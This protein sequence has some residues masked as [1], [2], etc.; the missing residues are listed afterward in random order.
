MDIHKLFSRSDF[1]NAKIVANN[2]GLYTGKQIGS[3][4]YVDPIL[5]LTDT[6]FATI[7]D[8]FIW[9]QSSNTIQQTTF[10]TIHKS[11]SLL[12][13]F[14]LTFKNFST[15][16]T[17]SQLQEWVQSASHHESWNPYG[18]KFSY[19]VG[20]SGTGTDAPAAPI[21]CRMIHKATLKPMEK[22]LNPN[23]KIEC[24]APTDFDPAVTPSTTDGLFNNVPAGYPYVL[25]DRGFNGDDK[26]RLYTLA[27]FK[28]GQS[29]RPGNREIYILE[30]KAGNSPLVVDGSCSLPVD[31][32][33]GNDTVIKA[34]VFFGSGNDTR[35]EVVNA[36][37][38]SMSGLLVSDNETRLYY[39]GDIDMTQRDSYGNAW[40]WK[41]PLVGGRLSS[42][43]GYNLK[44]V[45]LFV[46]NDTFFF[47]N[48]TQNYS[49]L[50]TISGMSR[51]TE[52]NTNI[53]TITELR[54]VDVV[55]FC[56][57]TYSGLEKFYL[58]NHWDTANYPVGGDGD[59]R[60][61]KPMGLIRASDKA[62]L[63][64]LLITLGAVE[65]KKVN[66]LVA[67]SAATTYYQSVK[68][69][70]QKHDPKFDPF[71]DD[72]D[73]DGCDCFIGNTGDLRDNPK[74]CTLADTAAEP[75]ISNQLYWPGSANALV[76]E[77]FF[78][79]FGGKYGTQLMSGSVPLNQQYL[80]DHHIYLNLDDILLCK[81]KA[82]GENYR[83][84]PLQINWNDF[85]GVFYGCPAADGGGITS[86]PVRVI[87]PKEMKNAFDIGKPRTYMSLVAYGL[88]S[89]SQGT[90]IDPNAKI[91]SFDEALALLTARRIAPPRNILI[92]DE[93]ETPKIIRSISPRFKSVRKSAI[94][95]DPSSVGA[96]FQA[97]TKPSLFG[98]PDP[99]LIDSVGQE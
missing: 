68:I 15:I 49:V 63:H 10:D 45:C 42:S 67:N 98:T 25:Q 61:Q 20:K 71:C 64:G 5:D 12:D 17:T 28:T 50:A 7:P 87:N 11:G 14:D 79:S 88:K 44:S 66:L 97:I 22:E 77:T 86:G 72:E 51:S 23:T 19:V 35:N 24:K 56:D 32:P 70:N 41:M 21:F 52:P 80:S 8:A 2:S 27:D 58:T 18:S 33:T 60:A 91:F 90:T 43:S 99:D 9:N 37:C 1:F 31:D 6:D 83:R 30:K 39:G 73:G 40:S 78:A 82:S 46:N 76:Y 69:L 84:R 57:E 26:G 38:L 65:D 48:N 54:A 74:D 95:K 13:R 16:P 93:S 81:F 53:T 59:R 89:V 3:N 92:K 94:A 96:I 55:N 36:Y 29:I 47:D 75:T 85:S 34:K 4:F 62:Q